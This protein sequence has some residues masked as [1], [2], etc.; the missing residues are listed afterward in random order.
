MERD[1]EPMPLP[2]GRER[3]VLGVLL[4]AAGQPVPVERLIA[5]LWADRPPA[6]ARAAI[7]TYVSRLRR[8]LA[9]AGTSGGTVP[10]TRRGDCYLLDVDPETVD[11]HRFRWLVGQ[12]STRAS[13][14]ERAR[15]LREALALWRGPALADVE[16][17]V[18]RDRVAGH[19]AEQR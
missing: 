10:L 2:G 7:H 11:F 16:P 4:L 19:L 12:A 3:C 5:L 1:G 8:A 14:G 9:A 18:L 17:P 13:P 15:I 6:N